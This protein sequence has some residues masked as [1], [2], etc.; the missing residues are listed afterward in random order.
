MSVLF[1]NLIN[2]PD[3]ENVFDVDPQEVLN[4]SNSIELTDV[5]D[6]D[7]YIGE[8]GHIKNSKLLPLAQVEAEL[9]NFPK[10]KTIVFICRSGRRSAMATQLLKANGFTEVYNLHGGMI[11]WN[12]LKLETVK[13]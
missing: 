5:R 6:P 4:Y 10:D 12:K 1:K 8:L 3:F 13:S 7:E 2:N 9:Y 11:Q